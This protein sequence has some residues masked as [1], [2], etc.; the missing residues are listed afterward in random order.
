[1]GINEPYIKHIEKTLKECDKDELSSILDIIVD[2]LYD[3]NILMVSKSY[4]GSINIP[5]TD[6]DYLM[7]N[8]GCDKS[9]SIIKHHLPYELVI[10]NG[11]I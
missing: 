9:H 6:S 2:E 3:R 4:N 7:V 8:Y 10:N 11:H 1:M 5:T